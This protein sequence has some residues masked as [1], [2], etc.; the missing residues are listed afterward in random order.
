MC[1]GLSRRQESYRLFKGEIVCWSSGVFSYWYATC[2]YGSGR[3]LPIVSPR[4]SNGWTWSVHPRCRP[5]RSAKE[6]LEFE[7]DPEQA[8]I[9]RLMYRLVVEE[10][11]GQNRIAKLYSI[12]RPIQ[13]R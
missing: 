12:K 7:I 8:D 10:G 11:Y 6:L 1:I 2:N 9:V 4:S 5:R 13:R 3:K